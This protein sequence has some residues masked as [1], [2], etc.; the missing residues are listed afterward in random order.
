MRNF[1]MLMIIII[2]SPCISAAC[3][4]PTPYD[5]S[6]IKSLLYKVE[7]CDGNISYIFGTMHSDNASVIKIAD[8]A[9]SYIS[10]S[11]T[12]LFEMD[13][14]EGQPN[15]IAKFFFIPP[16]HK[17]GLKEFAGNRLFNELVSR[18]H[19]KGLPIPPEALDRYRP[20]AA[21]MLLQI[22]PNENDGVVADA[23]LQNVAKKH[24]KQIVG[25]E[26]AEEQFRPFLRMPQD[27]QLSLLEDAVA[28]YEE[29]IEDTEKLKTFYLAGDIAQMEAL[30]SESFGNVKPREIG[31]YIERTLIVERN[32]LMAA[33]AERYIQRGGAFIAVG[34]LHLPGE[35]GLLRH[36]ERLGY[37]VTPVK[38]NT[39]VSDK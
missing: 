1:L 6:T 18:I 26:R 10:R 38:L 32:R 24:D 27:W 20:W 34:A 33:R 17:Q 29:A 5:K 39:L 9:S 12:A 31:E 2:L 35:S 37:D 4:P 8:E 11:N 16:T 22:P 23:Y 25:L 21:G 28:R 7:D 3:A 30:A 19:S 13:E 15:N 14:R 36:Y